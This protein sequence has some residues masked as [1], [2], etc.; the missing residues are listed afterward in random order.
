MRRLALIAVGA[1]V[2]ALALPGIAA[3]APTI[4]SFIVKS[5]DEF[6]NQQS[7]PIQL[8][9]SDN[10]FETLEM[11]FSVDGA[12]WTE[13]V[14]SSPTTDVVLPA[15]DGFHEVTIQVH[16]A[17]DETDSKSDSIVLDTVAP[18]TGREGYTSGWVNSSQSIKLTGED[19]LS[20]IDKVHWKLDEVAGEGESGAVVNVTGQGIHTLEYW[21]TDLAGNESARIPVEIKIDTTA[22]SVSSNAVGGWSN[23]SITLAAQ[24]AG[25]SGVATI[26]WKLNG[27]TTSFGSQVS[28]GNGVHALEYWSVDIA[29]N[30]SLHRIDTVRIDRTAPITTSN[31]VTTYERVASIGLAAADANSGVAYVEWTLDGGSWQRGPIPEVAT[32]GDHTLY[33]RSVDNAGNVEETKSV[34]FLVSSQTALQLI[35]PST[36]AY[37]S[38]AKLA[39]RLVN[40]AGVALGAGHKVTF[41]RTDGGFSMTVSTDSEGKVYLQAGALTSARSY[42]VSFAGEGFYG[43]SSAAYTFLPKVKL[44]RT[45]SFKTLKSGRTYYAKGTIGPKHAKS[46]GNKVRVL[47]YKQGKDKKYRL[48]KTVKASYSAIS[49]STTSSRYSAKIVL[50]KGNYQLRAYHPADSANAATYGSIDKFKVK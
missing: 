49:G 28:V 46:N 34:R 47:I 2:A 50:K 43:S 22:P 30:E 45:S 33:F 16:N 8:D 17:I 4:N 36:P 23:G 31:A 5:G 38:T 37:N 15:T 18:E 25:G 27:G 1:L 48:F 10:A 3:A 19:A 12:D 6:T 21:S 32:L 42:Q 13:W 44:S 14:P 24:D 29:G 41:R 40:S 11:R 26:A 20:G 7:V 35:A 39:V 9:V